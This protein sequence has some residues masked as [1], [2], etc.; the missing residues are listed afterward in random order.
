MKLKI[1]HQPSNS[2]SVTNNIPQYNHHLN[3]TQILFHFRFLFFFCRFLFT[4]L[5]FVARL[6]LLLTSNRTNRKYTAFSSSSTRLFCHRR[7]TF[8]LYSRR[9]VGGLF[10][11]SD[12]YLCRMRKSMII[13][14]I[15][16]RTRA[17]DPLCTVEYLFAAVRAIRVSVG[18]F[19]SLCEVGEQ[20]VIVSVSRVALV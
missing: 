3:Q 7:D 9:T 2:E 10:T 1:I 5:V 11:E 8:Y 20:L 17:G 18:N 12:Y 14:E 4:F 19:F 6:L 13:M 16:I 15:C